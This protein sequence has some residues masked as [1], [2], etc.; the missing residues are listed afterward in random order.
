MVGATAAAEEEPQSVDPDR[1]E[2]AAKL[3]GA[4]ERPIIIVG[5]GAQDASAEVTALA[6]MLQA[7]VAAHRMGQ[8]VLDARNPLSV[9]CVAGCELWGTADV[10][11]A[12]GTRL[13]MQLMQWGMDDELKIIRVDADRGGNGAH[14]PRPTPPCSATRR[15][16]CAR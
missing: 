13:Q 4:A 11:L 8:G 14:P 12:V 5:S 2:A 15:T 16:C 10:V 3:L 6:E 1:I 9:N 7:P